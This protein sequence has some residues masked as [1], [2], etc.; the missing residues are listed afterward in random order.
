MS[1]KGIGLY[2]DELYEETVENAQMGLRVD[3]SHGGSHRQLCAALAM[4]GRLEEAKQAMARLR[5]RM[6]DLTIAKVAKMIPIMNAADNE[7]WLDGLRK[8]GLPE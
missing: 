4:L 7:R 2:I 3:P 1:G 6:P 8:A 5:D